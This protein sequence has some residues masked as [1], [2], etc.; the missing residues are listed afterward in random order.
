[1]KPVNSPEQESIEVNYTDPTLRVELAIDPEAFHYFPEITD[2]EIQTGQERFFLLLGT[3]SGP[4]VELKGV[5]Q[6]EEPAGFYKEGV[7]EVSEVSM[8][9]LE[10]FFEHIKRSNPEYDGW[11]IVGDLHTHPTSERHQLEPHQR[12]FHPS[13]QDAHAWTQDYK[14]GVFSPNKPFVFIVAG[15]LE[16]GQ[17]GYGYYRVIKSEQGYQVTQLPESS[18]H[19]T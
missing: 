14:R 7:D 12:T 5:F 9:A 15:N 16:N 18:S 4:K 3:Y 6:L 8:N 19:Q 11:Q 17:T 2:E 1:M 10:A 13:P